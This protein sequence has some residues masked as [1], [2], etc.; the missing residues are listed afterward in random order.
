[1]P[2]IR[3]RCQRLA[4]APLMPAT[5]RALLGRYRPDLDAA[6]AD[7]VAGLAEG[8]IGRALELAR[9]GGVELYGTMLGLLARRPAIDPLALHGFADRLARPDAEDAYRAV[10]DLL[11]RLL[12]RLATAAARGGGSAAGEGAL[13]ERFAAAVPASRWAALREDVGETFARTDG[14][15]LDRKQAILSAFFAIERVAG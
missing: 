2:T 10:E 14:L 12:A 7:S 13:I 4:L 8:S 1:L 9:S 3:S 6:E 5:L 11:R 15:N